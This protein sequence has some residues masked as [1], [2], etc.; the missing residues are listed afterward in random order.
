M[1]GSSNILIDG[2]LAELGDY[3]LTLE[4]FN[5]LSQVQSALKTYKIT[6]KVIEPKSQTSF[7]EALEVISLTSDLD[8]SW[9]L[10]NIEEGCYPL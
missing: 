4:S 10:P 5:T 8:Q 9:R 6:I 3:I 7:S 1:T 2:E